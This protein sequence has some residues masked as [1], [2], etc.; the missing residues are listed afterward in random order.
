MRFILEIQK[1]CPNNSCSLE[2]QEMYLN[3]GELI[4][5][6]K[7][8]G[9]LS[10]AKDS[11]VKAVQVSVECELGLIKSLKNITV[12]ND[13]ELKSELAE[14]KYEKCFYS[15]LRSVN[16]SEIEA[17]HFFNNPCSS[18]VSEISIRQAVISEGCDP[19]NKVPNKRSGWTTGEILTTVASGALVVGL[20]AY[21]VFGKKSPASFN[22]IPRL[23]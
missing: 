20:F 8:N 4:A 15:K 12:S 23:G 14:H 21:K 16:D 22:N 7:I 5:I 2:V 3:N 18:K 19:S 6:T 9:D 11:A 17:R 1:Q 13:K 10:D